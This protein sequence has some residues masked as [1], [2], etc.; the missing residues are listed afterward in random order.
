MIEAGVE[1]YEAKPYQDVMESRRKAK[2][3]TFGS[4][5]RSSLHSKIYMFDRKKL[6]VGSFNL[7]PRSSVLNTE[8]GILFENREFCVQLGD[9][10]KDIV[11]KLAYRLEVRPNGKDEFGNE[12]KKIIWIENTDKGEVHYDVEP[13]TGGWRR[14]GTSIMG[15]LPVEDLL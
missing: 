10:W 11:D 1:L 3:Y 4:S 8:L 7:D 2:K 15:L 5:S 9:A 12:S 14:F 6:L 13:Y